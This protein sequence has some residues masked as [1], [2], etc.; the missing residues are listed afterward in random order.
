MGQQK[1]IMESS[2]KFEGEQ[3]RLAKVIARLTY[4]APL[5]VLRPEWTGLYDLREGGT[6]RVLVHLQNNGK[7]DAEDISGAIDAEFLERPPD[8]KFTGKDFIRGEPN[9]LAKFVKSPKGP[10]VLFRHTSPSQIS[11]EQYAKYIVGET[12][13]YI[14]GEFKYTDYTGTETTDHFCHLC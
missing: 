9:S 2:G 5:V 4:G 14:W 13:F 11:P 6:P 3:V 10:Y 8:P 1:V 7:R 12:N